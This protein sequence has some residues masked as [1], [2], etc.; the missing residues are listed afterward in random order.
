MTVRRTAADYFFFLLLV[1]AAEVLPLFLVVEAFLLRWADDFFAAGRFEEGLADL[2]VA[3]LEDFT[4]RE[5]GLRLKPRAR[6]LSFFGSSRARPSSA[7]L[8]TTV[9]SAPPT[10]APIGPATAAPRSAPVVTPA[11]VLLT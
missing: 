4:S 5:T 6:L 8:P 10:I 2:E 7:L 1:R 11:T 9:P 3:V